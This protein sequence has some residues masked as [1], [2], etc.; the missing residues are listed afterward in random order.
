VSLR[1]ICQLAE[2]NPDVVFLQVN[3][4]KHKSMCYS[5]HVHVLPF[6]RAGPPA[7]AAPM[8]P[9]PSSGT[10]WPSTA[11]TAAASTT[12]SSW[13]WLQTETCTSPTTTTTTSSSRALPHRDREDPGLFLC[14]M[15]LRSCSLRGLRAPSCC[16][17]G[18]GDS[19]TTRFSF[20][21]LYSSTHSLDP[22]LVVR[23]FPPSFFKMHVLY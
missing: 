4:E 22:L 15:M 19:H 13:P 16:R 11:R 23:D 1:Q 14:L 5:L 9:S 3:Y 18:P 12:R 20:H 17:P 2:K 8:Q 6:Y 7:S 10:R 21:C